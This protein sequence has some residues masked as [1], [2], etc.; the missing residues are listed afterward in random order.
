MENPLSDLLGTDPDYVSE[1]DADDDE[2]VPPHFNDDP[3]EAEDDDETDDEWESD[4]DED[5]EN[6]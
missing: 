2:A 1:L 6:I 5:E 4:E 3:A